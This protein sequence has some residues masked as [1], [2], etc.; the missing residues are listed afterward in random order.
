MMTYGPFF[1]HFLRPAPE[2][3][4]F[5]VFRPILPPFLPF[6]FPFFA[7]KPLIF[8]E[9][10][11]LP[12]EPALSHSPLKT[13]Y[14]SIKPLSLQDPPIFDQTPLRCGKLGKFHFYDDLWALFRP[15]FKTCSRNHTFSRFSSDFTPLFPVPHP[16]FYLQNPHFSEK[17][18]FTSR[19]S[20]PPF[21]PENPLFS[22]NYFHTLSTYP[23]PTP[24]LLRV[25]PRKSIKTQE[26][27]LK[28]RK[29]HKILNYPTPLPPT[30]FN[31]KPHQVR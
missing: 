2:T 3:T 27:P 21:P 31:Q 23:Y 25:P 1:V 20:P 16:I 22:S 15:F 24:Y 19:T 28:P 29:P 11:D 18:R 10:L 4:L 7:Q 14:F 6:S 30:S 5:H 26:T 12:S 13:H 9:N 17:P 8:P